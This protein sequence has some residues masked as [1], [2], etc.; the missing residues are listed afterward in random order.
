MPASSLQGY[1]ITAVDVAGKE[2]SPSRAAFTDGS[3]LDTLFVPS[4]DGSQIPG[5]INEKGTEE[6]GSGHS[7]SPTDPSSNSGKP[8]T[9]AKDSPS[10]PTGLKA[11]EDGAGIVISWKANTSKDKVKQYNVYFSD[12]EKGTYTKLGSVKDSTE[13]HYY[14]AAYNGYYK[15]TAVNDAGESKPSATIAYNR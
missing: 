13:F 9:N 14:A 1:Y 12:K 15:V 6:N 10:A 4:S 7:T 11:K 8:S 3:S 2:S 5:S